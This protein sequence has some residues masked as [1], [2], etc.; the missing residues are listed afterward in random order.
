MLKKIS[1][2]FFNGIGQLIITFLRA[3][4]VGGCTVAFLI[5]NINNFTDSSYGTNNLIIIVASFTFFPAFFVFLVEMFFWE[6]RK[7]TKKNKKE[8]KRIKNSNL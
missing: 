7:Q 2:G 8:E 3:F 4:L 1:F 6:L 5:I